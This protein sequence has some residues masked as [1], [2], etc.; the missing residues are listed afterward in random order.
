MSNS[1]AISDTL[2]S[3]WAGLGRRCAIREA[4]R[5]TA[6]D[7]LLDWSGRI[8]QVL[9][10]SLRQAGQRVALLLPNSAAFVAAFF[11]VARLG[12]VVAPLDVRYRAQELKY[13][14]DDL[15][16]VALVT[17][18]RYAEHLAAVLPEL[19][20]P[21]AVVHVAF[22]GGAALVSAGKRTGRALAAAG[23]APLV[24]LYTSGSTGQPKRVVRTHAHLAAE[25]EALRAVFDTTERDRFLGAAPFSHVNGMVRTMMAAMYNGATLYPVEEFKRREVL[26][27]VHRERIT[28]LGGVPQIYALLGQ[29]PARGEVDL[30]SLR[31]AF[32][33][34]APLR[35]ADA[36]HFN[37]RY[38]VAVRQLYGSTET[39]TISFNRDAEPCSRLDS[40]GTP[41]AAVSVSVLDE[42][43]QPAPPGAEG[44]LAVRSAYAAAGYLHNE[45]ATRASFRDGAYLTG[46]LGTKDAQGHIRITGRKKLMINRGGFKVNPYEVE[47]AIREHPKVDEV[48]V[49]A[50]PGPQG[51]DV[52]CAIVVS[53]QGCTAQEIIAHCRSLIADYKV[54]ARVE[55]RHGLP[56]SAAGKVL[57]ARL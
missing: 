10:P 49:H 3:L 44:E 5:D 38:G 52:V 47:A 25:L 13:Y 53:S 37:E 9:D 12:G 35:A 56:K 40:V 14:L 41:L 6:Y 28:F 39:G 33:S 30:S 29:T 8:S 45:A 16:A 18:S 26:E 20:N 42:Q 57:R 19:K 48:V 46:D 1:R 17:E 31:V 54:P 55:F 7:E 36:R 11:G 50:D 34:S 22:R 23:S 51:D 2:D 21:P 15:D 27:L 43:G 24:Q 32:S 4:E